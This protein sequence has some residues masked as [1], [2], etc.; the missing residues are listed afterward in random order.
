MLHLKNVLGLCVSVVGLFICLFY[1]NTIT[2]IL[3]MN[4]INDKIFDNVLVT[5]GDYSVQGEISPL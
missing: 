4:A 1:W 3:R 5:L 2:R